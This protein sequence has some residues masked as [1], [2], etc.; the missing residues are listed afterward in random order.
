MSVRQCLPDWLPVVP[1][2]L[3]KPLCYGTFGSAIAEARR[4][5]GWTQADLADRASVS[6]NYI[7]LIE[8]NQAGNLSISILARLAGTLGLDRVTL[9]KLYMLATGD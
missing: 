8:R 2:H 1:G 4:G 3:T 9:F 6:R 5:Q 7:S